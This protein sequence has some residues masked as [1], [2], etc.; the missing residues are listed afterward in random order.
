MSEIPYKTP[1]THM[2]TNHGS[3]S[4]TRLGGGLGIAAS[5]I[6]MMIFLGACAGFD[7]SLKLSVLPL[8]MSVPG[9][10]LSVIGGT[11]QANP[12]DTHVMAAVFPNI[13]GIVGALVMMAVWLKWTVFVH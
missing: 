13:L 7:A 2:G 1:G 11:R 5:I 12:E 9:L 8:L 4:L 3:G 10:V 6:G